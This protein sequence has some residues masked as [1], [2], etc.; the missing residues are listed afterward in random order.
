M[1]GGGLLGVGQHDEITWFFFSL[2]LCERSGTSLKPENIAP[3]F[4]FLMT[5]EYR[6]RSLRIQCEC[7]ASYPSITLELCLLC[8]S[9][10]FVLL[11]TYSF[12]TRVLQNRALC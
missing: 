7:M 4:Q 2:S 9:L 10:F 1:E 6:Y 3:V 5:P 8:V 12:R 11:I